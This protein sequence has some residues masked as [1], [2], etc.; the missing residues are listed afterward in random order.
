MT[1]LA[2]SQEAVTDEH[3]RRLGKLAARAHAELKAARPE[4]A[5]TLLAGVLAQ[6]AAAHRVDP[7]A[8]IGVKD[9]DLWLFYRKREGVRR[10]RERGRAKVYDFGPSS[11]GRHPDDPVEFRGRRVDVMTRTVDAPRG[12]DPADI[13]RS[14]L[15]R[16]AASPNLL[17]QRPVILVWPRSRAGEVVW[18]GSGSSRFTP[19]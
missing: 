5:G 16:G 11:L 18:G 3:L 17:R 10:V 19:A 6:G 12:A 13:V 9:F 8:G 15:A 2:R 1:D 7:D 14:W 4:L